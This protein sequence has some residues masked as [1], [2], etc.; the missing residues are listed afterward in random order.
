MFFQTANRIYKQ[1]GQERTN[2]KR[3]I[4]EEGGDSHYDALPI[5]DRQ[6]L[7]SD[8]FEAIEKLILKLKRI[9]RLRANTSFNATCLNDFLSENAPSARV[10]T[11]ESI[12]F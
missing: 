10:L 4:E 9:G 8:Q 6:T 5:F 7:T 11:G 1:A 12:I 3:R 2:I